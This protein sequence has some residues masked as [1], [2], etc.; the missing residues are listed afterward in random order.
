M[1]A[2]DYYTAYEAAKE[3]RARAAI[4]FASLAAYGLDIPVDHELAVN[5]RAADEHT[6]TA[7]MAWG[8]SRNTDNLI[9]AN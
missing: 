4:L 6:H 5:F 2:H 9:P 8:D 7:L 3:A 1:D